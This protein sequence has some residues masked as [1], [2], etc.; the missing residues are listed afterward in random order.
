LK[1]GSIT[2]YNDCVNNYAEG[3]A[4]LA[5]CCLNA[6]QSCYMDSCGGPEGS[7]G[8][9]CESNCSSAHHNCERDV[10][11][12]Y[13][14]ADKPGF[15][16]EPIS[17]INNSYFRLDWCH[18][19]GNDCGAPA[20][21]KFC[22]LEDGPGWVAHDF[23][24]APNIGGVTEVVGSGE[25]CD[26][27]GCDGFSFIQCVDTKEVWT[28]PTH[29]G[30]RVDA[31]KTWATDCGQGGADQFCEVKHGG[32]WYAHSFQEEASVGPTRVLGDG[33]LCNFSGC[34]GFSEVTCAYDPYMYSVADDSDSDGWGDRWDNCVGVPNPMQEDQDGD[35]MGDNCDPDPTRIPAC[36]DGI[37][38]DGDGLAD[39]ADPGC[40]S[41]SDT[42]ETSF[43]LA[44]DD[45]I[46]N[47]GDGLSDASDPHCT[48]PDAPDELG[49]CEDGFDDDGDSLVDSE[50]PDC[51]EASDDSEWHLEV[52]DFVVTDY[53]KEIVRIDPESGASTSL[54]RGAPLIAPMGVVID[55]E[56]RIFIADY[57]AD[58]IWHLDTDEDRLVAVS[59]GG[60]L[61]SPRYM[62]LDPAGDAIVCNKNDGSVVRV[63]LESGA[64]TVLDDSSSISFCEGVAV[65]TQGQIVAVDRSDE[66]LV[67]VHPGLANDEILVGG[68]VEPIDVAFMDD[69]TLIISDLVTQEIYSVDL[70]SRDQT[71]I[72]LGQ[73]LDEPRGLSLTDDGQIM[74]IDMIG[75]LIRIDPAQ[76]PAVNQTL[77]SPLDELSRP[78]EVVT[79]VPEPV[80]GASLMGGV[81]LLLQLVRSRRHRHC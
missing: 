43:D 78:V 63:D 47:D 36:N 27:A 37:D 71:T 64:Q 19:W 9:E 24:Q 73:Y 39:D 57:G 46:D 69:E 48:A 67:R 66:E 20:A 29:N 45:G 42:Y 53:D 2:G 4:S 1:A 41:W 8:W 54:Y 62:A 40:T 3:T 34:G 59:T 75:G 55:A 56:A 70:E 33:R 77:V 7:Q 6:E 11:T 18:L 17:P 35:T 52:G 14:R 80:M 79:Y 12:S 81:A 68:Y 65:N 58:T 49:A 72:S 74:L 30:E 23:E 5:L 76:S 16:L 44:C 50:D 21:H 31:C 32:R 28:D 26:A 25:H 61:N 22:R 13:A 60:A 15:H 38:N 51:T 10:A